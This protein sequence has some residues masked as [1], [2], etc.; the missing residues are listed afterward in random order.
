MTGRKNR[1]C[2]WL[3]SRSIFLLALFGK[4]EVSIIL[5][6]LNTSTFFCPPYSCCQ[7]ATPNFCSCQQVST[8]A[9]G[10][11]LAAA[12]AP[13]NIYL[14]NTLGLGQSK[15]GDGGSVTKRQLLHGPVTLL[16]FGPQGLMGFLRDIGLFFS[17]FL[18]S[19]DF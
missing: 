2:N 13:D 7:S 17:C 16:S 10:G 19:K 9:V 5:T 4:T 11:V 1:E 3:Y 14:A 8:Q 18:C 15:V 12:P 6:L